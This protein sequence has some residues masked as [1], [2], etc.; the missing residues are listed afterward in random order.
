MTDIAVPVVIMW[1][2]FDELADAVRKSGHPYRLRVVPHGERGA[3]VEVMVLPHGT[4]GWTTVED[5]CHVC[6]QM[7]EA[8]PLKN[9]RTPD[10]QRG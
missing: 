6:I 8:V 5:C 2:L 10:T 3:W 7:G 4:E 1:P 9:D